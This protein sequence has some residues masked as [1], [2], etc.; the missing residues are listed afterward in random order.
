MLAVWSLLG[1]DPPAPRAAPVYTA[2]SIVNAGD[3]Q[4]GA[5]AANTLGT[6]YGANMAYSTAA[7]TLN[8]IQGGVLPTVLGSS[9]TQV[10]VGSYP[11]DL[12]YVSPTQI[13][14]LV[15]PNMLPVPVL[16]YVTIDGLVGPEIEI[17][18]APAAPGLFQLDPVNAV[19]T[20]ADG[21]VLTP[22]APAKPGDIVLLWATGLGKTSPPAIYGQLP[23]AAARLVEGA[24]LSILLDGIAVDPGAIQY[25]GQAPGFAGLYQINFTLPMSTAANPEIR[26]QLDDAISIPGV[27]LPVGL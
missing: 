15:P 16:V 3:N 2:L 10:F 19:A 12:Y 6:I 22:A 1:A 17:T 24:N 27:H 25:A 8:D 23:E 14:F 9:E 11:A 26:L 20:L 21:T 5:L 7:I 4:S 18:L 13:N